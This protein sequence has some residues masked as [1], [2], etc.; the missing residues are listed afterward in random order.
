M[1]I[2]AVAF[3]S[4]GYALVYWG[5]NNVV[6]WRTAGEYSPNSSLSAGTSAAPLGVLFGVQQTPDNKGTIPSHNVPFPYAVDGDGKRVTPQFDV[7]GGSNP[8]KPSGTT[9]PPAATGGTGGAFINPNYPGGNNPILNPPLPNFPIP[10]KP[11]GAKYGTTR[12]L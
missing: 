5:I 4:L 3:I 12:P 10:T 11:S 6:L 9:A 2:I 1:F 8:T 7:P